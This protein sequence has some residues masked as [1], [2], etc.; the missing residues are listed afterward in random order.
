MYKPEFPYL[1]NQV[2]ISSGRVVQ[3]S[4]DDFI[5]LFGY[6]GVAVSSPATFTVDANEKTII[7]SPQIQLGYEASQPVL[8]G[9][10]TV[11]QLGRLLDDLKEL[12]NALTQISAQNL[13]T[14]IPKIISTS[15]VLET[16]AKEVK[17]QL[18]SKC[19]SQNTFT[20]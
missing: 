7:A 3:H 15:Q 10:E 4:Y 8:L 5:F 6:K 16:T 13:E 18:N 9:K 12:S 1:G 19:L 14:S 17:A 11:T 2:I 20:K